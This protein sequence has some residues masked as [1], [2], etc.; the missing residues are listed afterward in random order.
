M[1]APDRKGFGREV[2]VEGGGETSRRG[3]R[4]SGKDSSDGGGKSW[5]GRPDA[6][7]NRPRGGKQRASIKGY[8]G[9]RPLNPTET[10]EWRHVVKSDDREEPPADHGRHTLEFQVPVDNI[11]QM[12]DSLD[13]WN[14]AERRSSGAMA[15]SRIV[16]NGLRRPM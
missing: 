12:S 1:R 13:R 4:D 7:T 10:S 2:A 14:T 5:Q 15:E 11:R 3:Q 9:G 8:I 16:V 6:V